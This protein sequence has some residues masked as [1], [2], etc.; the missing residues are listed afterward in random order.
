GSWLYDQ[1][2]R[3]F[4]IFLI[5]MVAALM[6]NEFYIFGAEIY[7]WD[8]LLVTGGLTFIIGLRLALNVPAKVDEALERLINRGAIQLDPSQLPELKR[9]LSAQTEKYAQWY[10]LFVG[11]AVSIG[12]LIVFQLRAQI[13]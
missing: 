7:R 10:G 8:A 12:F 3:H 9:K 4:I 5:I 11:A 6:L 2:Y 1:F 13:P